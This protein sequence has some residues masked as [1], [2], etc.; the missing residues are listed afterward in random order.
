MTLRTVEDGVDGKP[1]AAAVLADDLLGG[2]HVDAGDLVVGDV[3]LHPLDVGSEVAEHLVGLA[4]D[5]RKS[6]GVHLTG[7]R[8]GALDEVLRHCHFSVLNDA[9]GRS[10]PR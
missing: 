4:G 6:G 9:V 1:A 7:A 5:G 2:G 10:T 8:D 3:A